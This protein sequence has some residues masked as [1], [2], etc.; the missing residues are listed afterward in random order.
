MWFYHLE[1]YV[2]VYVL[3][4][5]KTSSVYDAIFNINNKP[6]DTEPCLNA[7]AYV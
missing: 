6:F 3:A 5:F 7:I 1:T 2:I 4:P